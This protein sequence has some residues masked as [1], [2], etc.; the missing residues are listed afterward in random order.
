M[1]NILPIYQY[2]M[3]KTISGYH[4]WPI[5]HIV[6]H[7]VLVSRS[8]SEMLHYVFL[9]LHLLF[10]LFLKFLELFPV[11]SSQLAVV[12]QPALF[13]GNHGRVVVGVAVVDAMVTMALGWDW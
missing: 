12:E 3:T 11:V 7:T 9:K 2:D 6:T 8:D 13:I 5:Y 4:F 1:P 10:V